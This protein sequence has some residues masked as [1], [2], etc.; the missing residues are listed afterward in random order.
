MK[1]AIVFALVLASLSAIS[2]EWAPEGATWYFSSYAP[3]GDAYLRVQYV[4]D[5]VILEKNCK[6]LEKIRF[7]EDYFTGYGE[8]W[9][10]DEYTY[11]ENGAVY[12]YQ[13]EQFYKLYD[14]NAIT[15]EEWDVNYKGTLGRVKVDSTGTEIINEIE[16]KW[17]AVSTV[18]GY[19]AGWYP[20]KI[21]ET[22]GNQIFLF[23]G[24]YECIVDGEEASGLRCYSDNTY[25]FYQ[26][27]WWDHECDYLLTDLPEQSS[28]LL[29][30]AY[31]NPCNDQLTLSFG[32]HDLLNKFCLINSL[33][34]VVFE[35]T[36]RNRETI[37]INTEAFT[38][39]IYYLKVTDLNGNNSYQKI[40]IL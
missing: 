39:G 8:I 4:R 32:K 12:Y 15:G 23:P 17:V 13:E 31:P 26:S 1:I 6:I 33:N 37:N 27:P 28:H 16:L 9:T 29:V 10:G 34:Q 5:T 35:E 19:C 7:Q 22:L 11:Y 38:S 21:Y 14:Y 2:Q 36:L 30:Q 25:G 20:S 3:Y 18:N 40:V 24:W